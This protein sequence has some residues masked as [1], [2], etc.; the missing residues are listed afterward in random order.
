MGFLRS[1]LA[2]SK[3]SAKQFKYHPRYKGSVELYKSYTRV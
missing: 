2:E 3:S 1:L